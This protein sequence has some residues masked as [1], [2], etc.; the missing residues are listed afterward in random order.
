[1]GAVNDFWPYFRAAVGRY[2]GQH[3][4]EIAAHARR[5]GSSEGAQAIGALLDGLPVVK[6]A[7][8]TE[9]LTE[10]SG[11]IASERKAT[12]RE[13]QQRLRAKRAE[14]GYQLGLL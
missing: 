10:R 1:M 8:M 3:S 13:R 9:L 6:Q 2:V 11:E 14:A 7:S 5:T 12:L 4:D